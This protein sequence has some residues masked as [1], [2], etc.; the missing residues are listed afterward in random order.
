VAAEVAAGA[1]VA[2]GAWVAGAAP[3]HAARI[4]LASASK[5]ISVNNFRIFLLLTK[6]ERFVQNV[7]ICLIDT[8]PARLGQ[9]PPFN[10]KIIFYKNLSA[11]KQATK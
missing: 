3:P 7:H 11:K 6:L 4:M 10:T 9:P 5:L 8:V 2:A 1:S